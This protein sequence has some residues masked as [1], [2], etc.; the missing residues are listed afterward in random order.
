MFNKLDYD[1]G[2]DTEWVIANYTGERAKN[3]LALCGVTGYLLIED[4]S[5][6]SRKDILV[7]FRR[8]ID[9]PT[10]EHMQVVNDYFKILEYDKRLRSNQGL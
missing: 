4:R 10:P 2:V 7:A 5:V 8:P 1:K 6:G 3:V 9:S